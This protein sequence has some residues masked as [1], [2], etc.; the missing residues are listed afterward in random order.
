MLISWHLAL[1]DRIAQTMSQKSGCLNEELFTL[2]WA[3]LIFPGTE[4]REEI[5]I[6]KHQ[7]MAS[8]TENCVPAAQNPARRDFRL[9]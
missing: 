6:G 8:L 7:V 2:S 5:A 9:R 3:F 1:C 4:E